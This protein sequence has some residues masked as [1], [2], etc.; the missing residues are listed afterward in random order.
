MGVHSR[1]PLLAGR[2]LELFREPAFERRPMPHARRVVSKS[3]IGGKGRVADRQAEAPPLR[4]APDSDREPVVARREGAIG[5]QVRMGRSEARR[6][7]A[8]GEPGL[9]RIAQE[10]SRRV[11]HGDFDPLAAAGAFAR[12]ERREQ[13]V[14][15]VE[16]R[17][18]VDDRDADPHR[19]PVASQ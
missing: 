19:S 14:Q 8:V 13:S 1:Q 3:G 15:A 6:F 7:A 16:R 5:H 4:L 17:Q 11:G 2:G 9:R 12:I 18:E 10:R